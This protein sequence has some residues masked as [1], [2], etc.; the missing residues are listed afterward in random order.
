MTHVGQEL[1][2]RLACPECLFF[3]QPEISYLLV[4]QLL[5]MIAMPNQTQ[6]SGSS[7]KTK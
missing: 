1:A 7:L 6:A 4:H 5:Q 2:F 3:C